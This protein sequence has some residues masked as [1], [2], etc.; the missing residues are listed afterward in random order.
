MPDDP[1][2]EP[3]RLPRL[4]PTSCPMCQ[5]EMRHGRLRT[6]GSLDST[7]FVEVEPA[8]AD[9]DRFRPI[10]VWVCDRCG[11]LELHTFAIEDD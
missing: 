5:G 8:S 7:V 11:Y 4:R 1:T 9:D 2:L 10:D 3:I 6:T